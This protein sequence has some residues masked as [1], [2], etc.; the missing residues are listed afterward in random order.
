MAGTRTSTRSPSTDPPFGQQDAAD[1]RRSHRPGVEVR[2]T[3]ETMAGV[4]VQSMPAR[5]ASHRHG[6]EPCRLDEHVLR[7]RGDHRV[8]TAHHSGQ[9]QGLHVV[10]NHQVFG[11]ERAF[12][13]VESLEPLALARAA[14][15][16]AALEFVEIERVRGLA[17]RQPDEVGGVDCIGDLFLLEQ[18]EVRGNVSAR[19]PVA[20]LA[21]GHLAQNARGESPAAIFG[22]DAHREASSRTANIVGAKC[23]SAFNSTP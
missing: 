11:I 17:H 15:D 22:L 12:H 7:L 4:G 9:A 3:L 2:A 6:L 23:S 19:K 10:G 21:D 20:R 18:P 16:D 1:Q 13:A 5:G 8:P 14:H